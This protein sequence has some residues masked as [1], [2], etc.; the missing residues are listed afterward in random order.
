MS[1]GSYT[2]RLLRSAHVKAYYTTDASGQLIS[3]IGVA[4]VKRYLEVAIELKEDG[5]TSHKKVLLS[6]VNWF[7]EHPKQC[8]IFPTP[9]EVWGVPRDGSS[10]IPVASFITRAVVSKAD[11]NQQYFSS[12][13]SVDSNSVFIVIHLQISV[14]N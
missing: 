13:V 12:L 10:F 8:N 5:K 1:C 7:E 2:S 3:T 4:S 14:S 9:V 11:C 6:H